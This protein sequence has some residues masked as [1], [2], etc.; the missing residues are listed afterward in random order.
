VPAA[1]DEYD[2]YVVPIARMVEGGDSVVAI[3]GHLPKLEFEITGMQS[4]TERAGIVAN[5]L[6]EGSN[7][8]QAARINAAQSGAA[9][10]GYW[11][12]PGLR[13]R[14][15][16]ATHCSRITLPLYP[17]YPL[18]PF[19]PAQAGTQ[20]PSLR[21][22]KFWIPASANERNQELVRPHPKTKCLA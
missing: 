14:F 13:C 16:G 19:V 21:A 22:C 5:H 4:N 7:L 11:S 12:Y 3:A 15:I 8:K 18:L 1:H 10:S 6:R 2:R 17:G 20:G 9:L